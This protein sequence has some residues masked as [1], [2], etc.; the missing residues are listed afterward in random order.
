MAKKL[1]IFDYDGVVVDSMRANLEAVRNA[2]ERLGYSAFPSIEY[3]RTARCISFEEWARQIGM[4]MESLPT[5]L[6]YIH[7]ELAKAAPTLPIF[8]DIPK[9]LEKLSRAHDLAI[10]TGNVSIAAERFL[11][12]HELLEHFLAIFGADTPGSKELKIRQL[13]SELR[14]P[15]ES[16]YYVGDAGTDIQ[17]GRLA[18]VKTIA[19]TW[20]FQGRDRLMEEDP[21]IIIDR[22]E[23]LLTAI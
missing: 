12:R 11:A 13:A 10:I 17:Q 15:L 14:Y 19:V 9:T 21:D 7:D 23:E 2:C 8:S 22:P 20:G 18:G 1:I 6:S 5:F 3:C 16:I 4:D